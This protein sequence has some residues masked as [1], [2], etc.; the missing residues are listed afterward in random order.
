[1]KRTWRDFA[2]DMGLV[3]GAATS[4]GLHLAGIVS[5]DSVETADDLMAAIEFATS[6]LPVRLTSCYFSSKGHFRCRSRSTTN[7]AVLVFWVDAD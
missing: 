2:L 3:A 4:S 6:G 5:G 7:K 1:M